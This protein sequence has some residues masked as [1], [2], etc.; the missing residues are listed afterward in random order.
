MANASTPPSGSDLSG[1]LEPKLVTVLREGLTA[2][3]LA[4]EA[5]AGVIFGI[6]A[7]PLAIAFGIASG[8][9]PAQGLATA[10]VAGFLVSALGGSRA[11]CSWYE[12]EREPAYDATRATPRFAALRE[13]RRVLALRERGLLEGAR[14]RRSAEAARAVSARGRH[15]TIAKPRAVASASI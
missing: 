9:S 7:L 4:R 10:I 1:R 3:D 15:V 5:T 14:A 12:L 11:A 2:R 6:V 8:V 13:R